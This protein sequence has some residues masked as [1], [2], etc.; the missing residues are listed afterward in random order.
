MKEEGGRRKEEGG[1]SIYKPILV[2]MG[3]AAGIFTANLERGNVM[4]YRAMKD[5]SVYVSTTNTHIYIYTHLPFFPFTYVDLKVD[6][7]HDTQPINT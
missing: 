6:P 3:G 2:M 4:V 5:E 1:I 7:G